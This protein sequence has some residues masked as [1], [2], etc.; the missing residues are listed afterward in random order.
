LDP[1]TTGYIANILANF[2]ET[3]RMRTLPGH[4]EATADH[5]TDML[6]ALPTATPEIAFMIHSHVGNYT[7]FVTGIFPGHIQQRAAHHGAPDISFYE[8]VGSMNYRLASDH[9]L[10]R[11]NHLA[12]V[13]RNIADH[14]HHVRQNLNDL[15]DRLL[16]IEPNGHLFS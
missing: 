3:H 6:A 15:A 13:Y 4:P 16:H 9:Q 1:D 8:E 7:L 12:D 11:R 14:F 2:I 10:A 5:V